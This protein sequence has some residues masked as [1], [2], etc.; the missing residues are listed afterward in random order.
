MPTCPTCDRTFGSQRG[1]RVH[2][3][4]SHDELLPNRTCASCA[5]KFYSKH[6]QKYCSDD[7]REDGVS[8]EGSDNPNFDGGKTT[9]ACEICSTEF[10]YYPSEKSGKYCSDCVETEDWQDPPDIEGEENPLWTGGKEDVS[11]T[12][13]GRIVQRYPSQLNADV[14]VCS[15]WCRGRWLAEEFT[16]EDHPHWN[17]GGNEAYG[18]G[19][20]KARDRALERDEY[21][22]AVCSKPKSE[23]GRNPDVHHIIPVRIFAESSSHTIED[24]HYLDNLISLCI[25]CHRKA[26]FRKISKDG[27]KQRVFE[28]SPD[29][30]GSRC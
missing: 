28:N 29:D 5:E 1:L 10:E 12:V 22:C 25:S 18:S 24:A 15:D 8:F 13:C 30:S 6:E 3:S 21:R 2:H 4:R 9:T 7:C 27:L 26:E 17:G 23:I 19:W 14:T 16:G 11:C 20:A